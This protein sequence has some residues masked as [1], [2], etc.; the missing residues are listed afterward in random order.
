MENAGGTTLIGEARVKG[1]VVEVNGKEIE[2]DNMIIASGSSLF[3]P[4]SR[5]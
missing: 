1:S 3:C 5:E 2:Y 4:E